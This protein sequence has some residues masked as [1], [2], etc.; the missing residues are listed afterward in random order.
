MWGLLAVCSV[1]VVFVIVSN[2]EAIRAGYEITSL[3][4]FPSAHR[5]FVFGERHLKVSDSGAYDIRL[6]GYFFWQAHMLN[7]KF[8]YVNHQLARV[9][10]LRGEFDVALHWINIEINNHGDSLPNTYYVR[11]LIQGF[12]GDYASSARDYER[13]LESD[14][15]NWA[16]LNDYAW[17]LLKAGR[18]TEAVIATQKGLGYYPENP[19]LLNSHAIALYESGD[20]VGALPFAQRALAVGEQMTEAD[21]LR[22]YPGNDPRI[23]KE[24]IAAFQKAAQDNIHSIEMKFPT[25]TV[26]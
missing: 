21:W 14:P 17:V 25:G 23:A 5:A 15:H 12:R 13:Y 3:R 9:A 1:T 10:F 20:V 4:L 7:P 18:F 8:P 19:W 26:Q 2:R 11:G 6:A 24:G 22:A 16:A